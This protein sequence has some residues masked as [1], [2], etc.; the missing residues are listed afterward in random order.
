MQ[1]MLKYRGALRSN[2]NVTPQPLPDRNVPGDTFVK[3]N[4]TM[5]YASLFVVYITKYNI[6]QTCNILAI[7]LKLRKKLRKTLGKLNWTL[8]TPGILLDQ[9]RNYLMKKNTVCSLRDK[10]QSASS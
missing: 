8:V 5:A 6:H 2:W 4:S 3:V 9:H 10:H 7:L 1:G